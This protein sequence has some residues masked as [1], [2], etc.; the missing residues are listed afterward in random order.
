MWNQ[1]PGA[2]RLSPCPHPGGHL[3]LASLP[4]FSA[5]SYLMWALVPLSCSAASQPPSPP[6]ALQD[7][8]IFLK[9]HFHQTALTNNP[10]LPSDF[11]ASHPLLPCALGSCSSPIVGLLPSLISLFQAEIPAPDFPYFIPLVWQRI[12]AHDLLPSILLA[13]TSFGQSS[14]P[15][16]SRTFFSGHSPP[17]LPLWSSSRTP[18][19]GAVCGP[20]SSFLIG[21]HFLRDA[22]HTLRTLESQ[23]LLGLTWL[24]H[25]S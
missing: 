24:N 9:H 19:I 13:L 2:D 21:C 23:T 6:S 18:G 15:D 1:C 17:P 14:L 20:I 22:I 16:H 4:H 11:P 25:M 7:E 8:I 5:S 3:A 12:M 10:V